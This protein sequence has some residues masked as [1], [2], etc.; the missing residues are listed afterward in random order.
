[1]ALLVHAKS[2]SGWQGRWWR[3]GDSLRVDAGGPFDTYW[4]RLERR[5]SALTGSVRH[6]T[7]ILIQDSAGVYRPA[8]HQVDWTAT[9][10]EC[11][12][13]PRAGRLPQ[14]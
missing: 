4:L 13:L 7:D 14:N 5:G 8:E 12:R 9:Q 10:V 1:M 6:A 2:E 11:A 3:Y